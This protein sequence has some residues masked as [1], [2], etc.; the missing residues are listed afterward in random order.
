MCATEKFSASG[1]CFHELRRRSKTVRSNG[2][3]W[4]GHP[5]GTRGAGNGYWSEQDMD[6]IYRP[7]TICYSV[8]LTFLLSYF[9]VAVLLPPPPPRSS[10]VPAP[11]QSL[12][13]CVAPVRPFSPDRKPRASSDRAP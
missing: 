10:R 7:C 2:W 13:R 12:T 11:V 3:P 5:G 6:M 9:R 1:G 4:P 8:D